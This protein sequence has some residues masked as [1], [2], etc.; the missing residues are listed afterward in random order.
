MNVVQFVDVVNTFRKLF[1]EERVFSSLKTKYKL[2]K[3]YQKLEQQNSLL[4]NARKD[5]VQKYGVELEKGTWTVEEENVKKFSDEL[6]DIFDSLGINSDL[7]QLS[8]EE[9]MAILS[10][11]VHLTSI[12]LLS[13]E[14]L[15]NVPNSN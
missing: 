5:L 11:D 9:F 4:E 6:I 2:L 12:E 8:D 14:L 7:P 10:E 1:Q 13:L 3:T 15:K